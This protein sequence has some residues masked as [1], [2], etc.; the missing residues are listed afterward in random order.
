MNPLLRALID[1]GHLMGVALAACILGAT[2][3]LLA[4][5]HHSHPF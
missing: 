1:L 2:I 3:V 4:V 5:L